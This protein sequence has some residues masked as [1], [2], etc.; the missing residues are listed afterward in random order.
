MGAFGGKT[1]DML[2]H[3]ENPLKFWERRDVVALDERRVAAGVKEAT[4]SRYEIPEW[5]AYGYDSSKPAQRI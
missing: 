5:V 1:E 2:L 3:P 4:A